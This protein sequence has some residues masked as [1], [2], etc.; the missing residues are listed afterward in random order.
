MGEECGFE[1]LSV[2]L[3]VRIKPQYEAP[4]KLQIENEIKRSNWT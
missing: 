2:Q 3:E 1:I 4:D